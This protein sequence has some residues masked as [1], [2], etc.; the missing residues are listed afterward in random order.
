MS[1]LKHLNLTEKDFDLLVDGLDSLPEKGMAGEFV[2]ELFG[3]MMTKDDP[4]SR[5]KLQMER[6]KRQR[7]RE[8]R[9]KTMK[10]DIKILQGKLLML[11]RYLIQQGALNET[12]EII[13]HIS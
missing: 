6:E 12:Y 2:G 8:E 4:D 3:S 1:E 7:E 9:N 5:N 10:E 11:K 13:N